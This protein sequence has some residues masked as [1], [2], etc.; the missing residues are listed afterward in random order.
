MSDQCC[1]LLLGAL[2]S[3]QRTVSMLFTV[4][5]LF[6]VGHHERREY[7]GAVGGAFASSFVVQQGWSRVGEAKADVA[8][9]IPYG[10]I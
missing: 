1:L 4:L 6:A 5:T 8:L 7:D 2:V 10:L 9:E 3:F